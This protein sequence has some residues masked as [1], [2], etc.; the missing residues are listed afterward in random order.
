[1]L[2]NLGQPGDPDVVLSQPDLCSLRSAQGDGNCLFRALSY[3]VTGSEA[4][5]MELCEGITSYMLSTENLLVGYDSTGHANYLVPFNVN[6]VQEY[7]DNTGKAINLTLGTGL[8]TICFCCMFNVNL[9]TY[10][11]C[12][13]QHLGC[14]QSSQH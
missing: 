12:R 11:T 2:V 14:L 9:Y 1:M 6:S 7:I 3:V 13:L 8:E 5:H 4:Q 10:D